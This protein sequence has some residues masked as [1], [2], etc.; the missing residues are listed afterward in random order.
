MNT[1]ASRHRP[2]V[3]RLIGGLL[4]T[5]VLAS[6][7]RVWLGPFPVLPRA[8]AQIP[9]SGKQRFEL[10]DQAQ[11]TNHLLE[12]ILATL[13]EGTLNVRLA[14]TD[15]NAKGESGRGKKASRR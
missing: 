3:P 7:L 14:G 1:N 2:L 8:Q 15:K 10:I 4:L 6:C 9:D 13:R 5:F 12:Q 11:K